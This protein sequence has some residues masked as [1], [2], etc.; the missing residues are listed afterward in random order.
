MRVKEKGRIDA[1][2]LEVRFCAVIGSLKVYKAEGSGD[3]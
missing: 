3:L 1:K 2:D